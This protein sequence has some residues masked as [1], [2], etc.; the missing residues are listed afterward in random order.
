VVRPKRAI[1]MVQDG[2]AAG[3]DLMIGTCA[4]EWRLFIWGLPKALQDLIPDP[5]IAPYFVNAGRTPDEVL[6]MYGS[7]RPG[8]TRREL[9]AAVETDQ[10]FTLPA[11]RLAEAQLGHH[12][13][14][15]MYRFSW[16]TPV[17]D[18]SLGACHALELPFVFD[19]LEQSADFV[20]S[21]PP[22]DL[23]EDIHRAWVRFAATGDPGSLGG[24]DWPTYDTDRRPVMDF[25]TGRQV[26][27]DPNSEERQL[28]DGLT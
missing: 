5:D 8:A 6:K 20:G 18:G 9:L 19:M 11:I 7:T 12:D 27:N 10:M 14:V 22:A 4:E 25:N 15:R 17:L 28:W 1:D 23:A 2:S 24:S 3:I 16:P 26:I 21:S 13:N